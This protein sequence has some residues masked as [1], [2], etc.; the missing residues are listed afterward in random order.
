MN[1]VKSIIKLSIWKKLRISL[2]SFAFL[3]AL[4]VA[5]KRCYQVA[6]DG[7]A[8]MGNIRGYEA[9]RMPIISAGN[10]FSFPPG[11]TWLLV[12]MRRWIPPNGLE[13][14]ILHL[15]SCRTHLSF[16]DIINWLL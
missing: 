3:F 16:H 15:H 10:G 11:R 14:P 4:A 1:D 2:D 8:G 13:R 7:V 5:S 6:V 12:P 9:Y